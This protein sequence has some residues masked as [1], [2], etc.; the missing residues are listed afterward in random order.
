M[1]SDRRLGM[2]A[3]ACL[4]VGCTGGEQAESGAT[5]TP[6]AE[7]TEAAD[8]AKQAQAE[9]AIANGAGGEWTFGHEVADATPVAIASLN[10]EP[11]SYAGK[12]V[13]IEG[14]VASVCKHMGCWVEV[15]GADGEKILVS[16]V[17][18]DVLIPKNCEGKPITV[19]G[20]FIENA[21]DEAG[22]EPTYTLDMDAVGLTASPAS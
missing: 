10:T 7:S 3:L 11:A 14:K 15:Q 17:E 2:L 12:V 1:K 19:Q 13:A 16:S 5:E 22:G 8:A 18:H 21:P 9:E 4:L 20:T 6:A